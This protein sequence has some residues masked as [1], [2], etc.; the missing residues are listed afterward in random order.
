VAALTS[1]TSWYTTPENVEHIAYVGTDQRIHE[2]FRAIRPDGQWTHGD[3]PGGV[4]TAP[5]VAALTSPTSWYTTPENFQHIAYVGADDQRIH[6]LF[7]QIGGSGGW[8]HDP[9]DTPGT[10]EGAPQVAA[11]TSPT[12]WYTT[13]ENFQHIAYVGADDQR[14]HELFYLITPPPTGVTPDQLAIFNKHNTFRDK[15]CTPRV[16]WSAEAAA[17]AQ[18]WANG[19]NKDNAGNF[20]H[21]KDCGPGNRFG[22]N[23]GWAFKTF[24]GQPVL[25]GLTPEDA[26]S[27]WYCEIQN[28]NFDQPNLVG[29]ETTACMPP[30]NGHFTQVIWQATTHIGCASANCP[31]NQGRLGTLWVC[32]Y[33]PPGNDPRTL[34]DNVKRACR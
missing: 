24:N 31:D 7:F 29:G 6:E 22:E 32:E 9:N 25:P 16:Q 23:L 20:C 28:Y 11:R 12:S 5:Q 8:V 10:A 13:P 30:V 1:P 26:V 33:D 21:Q 34:Q 3:P 18:A 2:L 17:N 19:C 15:H 27:N 4:A 14:I